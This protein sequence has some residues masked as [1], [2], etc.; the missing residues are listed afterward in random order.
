MRQRDEPLFPQSW[1][2]L[3]SSSLLAFFLVSLS[4]PT[5]PGRSETHFC[6]SPHPTVLLCP[7]SLICA[8]RPR[9]QAWILDWTLGG[10]KHDHVLPL[11]R[12]DLPAGLPSLRRKLEVSGITWPYVIWTSPLSFVP[13]ISPF[14]SH[15][16]HQA[17][18]YFGTFALTGSVF[19]LGT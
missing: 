9:S 6:F 18:S 8:P 19:P 2:D 3:M 12:T 14:Q 17:S 5:N 1:E 11:Y 13:D 10:P 16:P 15:W 4:S 7:S